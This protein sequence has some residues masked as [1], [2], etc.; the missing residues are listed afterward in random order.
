ML[1][2]LRDFSVTTR[3]GELA[4][5]IAYS[6]WHWCRGY[7]TVTDFVSFIT[8]AG[9]AIPAGA[10]AADYIMF[11]P[12][13]G[14]LAL[15]EAKGTRS[16]DHT[17]AMASAMR[18]CRTAL[19]YSHMPR[20]YGC[21]LTLN[22]PTGPGVL[23]VRDPDKLTETSPTLRHDLFRHSYASWF[24]LAGLQR[25]LRIG[26]AHHCGVQVDWISIKDWPRR[27]RIC[28]TR[29]VNWLANLSVLTRNR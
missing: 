2:V 9:L 20:A 18:Q 25:E 29:C 10:Q 27:N 1:G 3:V 12:A 24:E 4:Q 11:D 5:G 19:T 23:H 13:S 21:I 22:A 26:V 28:M 8:S 17:Q 6:Y 14:N 7:R 15:M 16:G